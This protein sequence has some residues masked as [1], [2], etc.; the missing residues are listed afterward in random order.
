MVKPYE[1]VQRCV[2]FIQNQDVDHQKSHNF[3]FKTYVF[4]F[5]REFF[6]WLVQSSK[7][8]TVQVVE[9]ISSTLRAGDTQRDGPFLFFFFSGAVRRS[10][11]V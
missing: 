8:V 6:W 1:T 3:T 4:D 2:K 11:R 7:D 5:F 10:S 9:Q